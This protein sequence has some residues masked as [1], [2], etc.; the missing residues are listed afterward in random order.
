[1]KRFIKSS[2]IKAKQ[3]PVSLKKYKDI[4]QK[5][6][7]DIYDDG[8]TLSNN[9]IEAK[10]RKACYVY[11]DIRK[12]PYTHNWYDSDFGRL[13]KPEDAFQINWDI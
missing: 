2:I 1:M 3:Y 5:Q 13:Q 12:N 11:D 7:N 4:I 8:T 10:Y 6:I 9:I